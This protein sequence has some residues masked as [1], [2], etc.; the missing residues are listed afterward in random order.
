MRRIIGAMTQDVASKDLVPRV[1]GAGWGR[2]GTASTKRALELLGLGPCHHMEEVIKHPP[3]VPTWERAARGETIDWKTFM[4][5]WGSCVD[6][7]S[8]IYYRELMEAFPDAK[9]ILSVRDADSWYA[10]MGET[11]VPML[12]RFPNR[13]VMP[14]L[15]H[16]GAP[17]RAVGQ[18][19]IRREVI[20]RFSDREHVKK[21]F[22]DHTEQVKRVVPAERLLVFEAKQGWE[23]LCAFLGVPV[24]KEPFPRLN[25]TAEFKKRV[26]AATVISWLLLLVPIAIAIAVISLV[27]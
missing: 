4:R 22:N 1:I 26:F 8:A 25:D 16:L 11:I 14:Y 2:T 18:T 15:P 19:Q 24:P 23:P 7:P 12:S 9:V 10:S 5:G 20:D 3:E 27:L 6:F 21:V 13:I 17:S